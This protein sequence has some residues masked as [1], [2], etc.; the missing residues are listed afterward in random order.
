MTTTKETVIF[1]GGC[2]WCT[3]AVFAALKGV[4]LVTPGYMGGTIKNPTYEQVCS[5][6]SGHVEV[7]KVDFDPTAVSFEDLLAV[8]FYTHDPTTRNRQG[9]D[10]GPQ[11]HSTIFYMNEEQRLAAE[12]L[13]KELNE[14]LAYGVGHPVVTDVRLAMEFYAAED[15]HQKYYES[16]KDAPYCQLIIEPKLDKLREKFEKLLRDPI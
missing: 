5:G 15:Y 7:T 10:V 13:I 6:D 3:E 16:H 12:S 11:Y 14:S 1:G 4:I 9:N 8:F 2:F